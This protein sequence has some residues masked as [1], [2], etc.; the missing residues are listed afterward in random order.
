MPMPGLDKRQRD[1]MRAGP[2]VER[3]TANLW[4]VTA[5]HGL[6]VSAA[7]PGDEDQYLD[8]ALGLG[9]QRAIH[10]DG[11]SFPREV[12]QAGQVP[13]ATTIGEGIADRSI[14]SAFAPASHSCS[15]A[16]L[17]DSKSR[18][19]FIRPTFGRD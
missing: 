13:E 6:G 1:A 15:T 8:D 3:D 11:R 14:S 7:F 18:L 17:R 4:T 12:I 16:K 5:N 10:F 2:L 9:G 19:F